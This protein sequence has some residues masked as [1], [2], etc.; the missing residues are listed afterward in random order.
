MA[1]AVTY[2]EDL[3][4]HTTY[5]RCQS[6]RE[7][8]ATQLEVSSQK[9][10]AKRELESMISD[11]E[12]ELLSVEMDANANMSQAAL[13]RHMKRVF[14]KDST[15]QQLRKQ[16]R[17]V[18]AEFDESDAAR[19]LIEADIRIETARLVELGGYFQYLGAAKMAQ[20]R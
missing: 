6:L 11:L 9:R 3:G 4:V 5:E 14:A 7:G 13:D 8:L 17:E 2:A 20:T 12:F 16:L 10:K 19:S 18:S 15:H 1:N